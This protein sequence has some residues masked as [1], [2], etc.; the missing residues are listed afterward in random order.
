M[1]IAGQKRRFWTFAYRTA[2]V[3]ATAYLARVSGM[4]E[5][6]ETQCGMA[7][8]NTWKAVYA[9]WTLVLAFL[10]AI[11]VDGAVFGIKSRQ[12]LGE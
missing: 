4:Q 8:D 7:P 2:I 6:M 5:V 12:E 1:S 9:G 3:L 11:T 10:A